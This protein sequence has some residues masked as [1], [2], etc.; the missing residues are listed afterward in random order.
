MFS[1]RSFNYNRNY[2]CELVFLLTGKK[3]KG[4]GM[5]TI[6]GTHKVNNSFLVLYV[7]GCRLHVVE[8]AEIKLQLLY[9]LFN[10]AMSARLPIPTEK[11]KKI[12]IECCV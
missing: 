8:H 3:K 7:R 11:I 5:Q 6:S 1:E 12:I 4:G 10:T 2:F 9:D